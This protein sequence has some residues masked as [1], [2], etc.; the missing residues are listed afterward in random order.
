PLTD[1]FTV[2]SG[3]V[4]Y[5]RVSDVVF[6]LRLL[7]GQLSLSLW[8]VAPYVDAIRYFVQTTDPAL[9]ESD[10]SLSIS[11]VLDRYRDMLNAKVQRFV[12]EVESV[13]GGAL[14]TQAM[15]EA[16]SWIGTN[17]YTT[18]FA[19]DF[20]AVVQYVHAIAAART[21]QVVTD[22]ALDI[23]HP[24]VGKKPSDYAAIV[25]ANDECSVQYRWYK[26]QVTNNETT[27]VQM[28]SSELFVHGVQY[29]AE[30]TIRTAQ[31]KKFADDI[32]INTFFSVHPMYTVHSAVKENATTARLRIV[33]PSLTEPTLDFGGISFAYQSS[34]KKYV[35]TTVL[36][37]PHTENTSTR[38]VTINRPQWA[39]HSYTVDWIGVHVLRGASGQ[40]LDVRVPNNPLTTTRTG[41]VIVRLADT[42]FELRVAQEPPPPP[43]PAPPQPAPSQ[44]APPQPAPQPAPPPPQ[45][46][47]EQAPPPQ[48]TERLAPP[49]ALPDPDA[50]I[51]SVSKEGSKSAPTSARAIE[52]MNN[53]RALDDVRQALLALRSEDERLSRA[54]GI[55]VGD[56]LAQLLVRSS[57]TS[58]SDLPSVRTMIACATALFSVAQPDSVGVIAAR[59]IEAIK[60]NASQ[61]RSPRDRTVVSR[62]VQH[63]AEQAATAA[64]TVPVQP[65]VERDRA[66]VQW[67][68]TMT[69]LVRL[70]AQLAQKTAQSLSVPDMATTVRVDVAQMQKTV[71]G[72]I[73]GV[74]VQQLAALG[75]QRL[76]IATPEVRWSAPVAAFAQ[77][78]S[79]VAGPSVPESRGSAVHGRVHASVQ[80]RVQR[81]ATDQL[82][83]YIP[84]T[85]DRARV[86]RIDDDG[87]IEAVVAT[88]DAGLG[89]FVVRTDRGGA[90]VVVDA[91]A[92]Y[93]DVPSTHWA[94]E[95]ID[96][97]TIGGVVLG[98]SER[99]F[100][101]DARVRRAEFAKMIVR[102][103][104]VPLIGNE[105][106]FSD[107]PVSEWYAPYVAAAVKAGMIKGFPDGT[108][109]PDKPITREQLAVMIASAVNTHNDSIALTFRDA[110]SIAPYA[111]DAIARI[112]A[113]DVLRGRE[114]GTFDPKATPTRA[115]TAMAVHRLRP[116]LFGW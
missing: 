46:A 88:Y 29:E 3:T 68:E 27:Y 76:E 98:Q 31:W 75:V 108:F 26:P 38:T 50:A 15:R 77:S 81:M 16:Q 11:A 72:T 107:V 65:L 44:P 34:T 2:L 20:S 63:V 49:T 37:V 1:I 113:L 87:A 85:V 96:A 102:A 115:E 54:D 62:F 21:V 32:N 86:L 57:T 90:F 47:P 82:M 7:G 12:S 30:L 39:V 112:V 52:A 99:A 60:T 78:T 66:I 40:S 55:A 13:T 17:Q 59:V 109:G 48:P 4:E 106:A 116:L 100:A 58:T 6:V 93:D 84:S 41:S 36:S 97:L 42:F 45:P 70:H 18:D 89:T 95:A 9:I 101:P 79:F 73:D 19:G 56:A 35:S 111:R 92:A 80:L 105:T 33:F 61:Q 74:A 28:G 71:H 8:D 67:D 14:R 64:S 53:P 91:D 94:K 22:G 110:A 51:Q 43:Q 10:A 114:D 104:G 5:R 83:V 69:K 103:R 23:V 24:M 25:W